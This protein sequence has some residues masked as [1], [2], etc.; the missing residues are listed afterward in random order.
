ML[1]HIQFQPL[2][3]KGPDATTFLQGQLTCDMS[4]ITDQPSFGAY[5]DNRGRMIANFMIEVINDGFRL[6]LPNGLRDVF[7]EIIQKY[8]AFSQVEMQTIDD[9]TPSF[10]TNRLTNIQNNI[11]WL[12]PETSAKF[13]PQMINWE[14]LGGVSFTKGC[15]LG[16]EIVARTQHLGKLKRHLHQFTAVGSRLPA[17]GSH[18]LANETTV[19][20]ICDVT[21][22]NEKQ[23]FGL[24][25][26]EDRA[27]DQTLSTE[28]TAYIVSLS[29]KK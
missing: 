3:I 8:A 7:V 11:T 10:E 24:A 20:T 29:D 27:L 15:F 1:E 14:K 6:W 25:V 19:G 12:A 9:L 2:L 26:I 5:C 13:T 18:I 16:Q 23:L 22:N 4:T 28:E 17:I 21:L